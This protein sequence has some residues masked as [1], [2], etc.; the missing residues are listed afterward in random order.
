MTSMAPQERTP[1]SLL[2]VINE[3]VATEAS[4]LMSFCCVVHMTIFQYAL[5]QE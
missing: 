5:L 4:L 2:D 3:H 1:V